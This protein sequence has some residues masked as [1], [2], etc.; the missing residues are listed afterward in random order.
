M[1]IISFEMLV[2]GLL[3]ESAY[4]AGIPLWLHTTAGL[5]AVG[6]GLIG[7][8][9]TITRLP[10]HR[11]SHAARTLPAVKIL[12]AL[13][14]LAFSASLLWE[15]FRPLPVVPGA[16]R[17]AVAFFD[18][19][20]RYMERFY[21]RK[22]DVDWAN[23]RRQAYRRIEGA[24][25]PRETFGAVRATI[26]SLGKDAHNELVDANWRAELS[27]NAP[28]SIK[29]PK[30]RLPVITARLTKDGIAYVSVPWFASDV[31]WGSL[32][33]LRDPE[34]RAHARRLREKLLALDEMNP[35][36]WII[37]LRMNQGGSMWPTLDGLASLIGEGRVAALDMP[38]FD[39]RI[40]TW[41][42]SGNSYSGTPWFA[43]LGSR[44]LT[45]KN[46]A[47]P[48]AILAGPATASAGEGV[49]V[50]FK[51]RPHTRQ[52]GRPTFGVPTSPDGYALGHGV[53]LF[54]TIA[55]QM[56]RRGRS[57]DGPIPPDEE[58]KE[59]GRDDTSPIIA[60][61][62]RWIKIETLADSRV[63]KK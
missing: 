31:G 38:Q 29:H 10:W 9:R 61:A 52:F 40:D 59:S 33:R 24:Q 6:T 62:T 17:E 49:L 41:I 4:T 27:S 30:F 25:T 3:F 60:A 53:T 18:N 34:G 12:S 15:R 26:A 21:L 11:A 2:S 22:A 14:V 44:R 19:A 43:G 57:Y 58:I 1:L 35:Q 7:L 47:A 48:L 46:G 37:D 32:Y 51:G 5:A 16:S 42:V 54:I 56:D 36:G 63:K 28:P 50:A 55:R 45:L 8:I 39:R 13:A 23:F 20:L